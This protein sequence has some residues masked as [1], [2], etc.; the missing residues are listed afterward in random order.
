MS[1]R[2]PA[3]ANRA[4]FLSYASQDVDAARQICAALRSAGVEV[5]FDADGGLEHGDEWDAKIRRQIKECVLF[6]PL[7]SAS[8]QARLEGYFRIEWELAAER[9]MG[10]ASGVPFILPIVI[11]DTREADALV[12]DRFRK[13]Q[14][15]R[16]PA[17]AV[18]PEVQARLLKLWSHR[19]GVLSHQAAP[20][21]ASS[22]SRFSRP[23]LQLDRGLAAIVFTDVVGYSQRMQR[24][25]A[26]TMA[27]VKADFALIRE[28]CTDQGGEVLNTM[29]DGLLL[30]FP[31]AV[32]AVTCA[33]QIQSEFGARRTLLPPEQTLAHRMGVHIGDVFRQEAGGVAGDGV[34]IAARLEGKAPPGGVCISQTVYD[35]VKG[36]VPMQA[37]FVG[38]ESFKNITQPIPVWHIAAEG[39]APPSRPRLSMA[40][41][42]RRRLRPALTVGVVA[43]AVAGGWLWS[44]RAEPSAAMTAGPTAAKKSAVAPARDQSVAVL[45][46]TNL[47]EDKANEYFSDGVCEELLTVLQKIPGL[48]VVARTSAFSFKGT[49]ATAQQIGAALGAALLVDGS[50]Q[51]AGEVVRIVVHV[52]RTATGEQVWSEDYRWEKKE[53]LFTKQSEIAQTVV[54]QL[55]GQLGGAPVD[56]A[57]KAEIK[58]QVQAAEK[59]GTKN[60]EAHELFLRGRSGFSQLSET[61]AAKRLD[62]FQR[63][64]ELD[65]QFAQAWAWVARVYTL[66]G[67]WGRTVADVDENFVQARRAADRALEL[68]PDLAEGYCARMEIQC[69]YDFNWTGAKRSLQRALA[70][71]PTNADI[72][73]SGAR[74]ACVFNQL[75]QALAL[76]RQALQ[77]DPLNKELR[78]ETMVWQAEIHTQ[79]GR[80]SEAETEYQRIVELGGAGSHGDLALNQTLQRKYAEAVATASQEKTEWQ[81]LL[82]LAVAQWGQGNR[83]EAEAALQKFVADYPEMCAYQIAMAYAYR[84]EA[85]KAFAW[86][87][88]AYRQR[89]SGF[90]WFLS[91]P[92]LRN[93]HADP[94]W[95]A[96]VRKLGLAEDQLK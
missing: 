75:D 90:Q 31:S 67:Q 11:D 94:R 6:L 70:L 55:R 81:R 7:V 65:P 37:V 35:T 41:H 14:W 45:P 3:A 51:K 50:V 15:T 17:G 68:E 92:F 2:Q 73:A 74:L 57:A 40:R 9:A 19:V 1:D 26:G 30:C 8:T 78:I 56:L 82:A 61:G 69:A 53:D 13:V 64:V 20:G 4:V 22:F 58:A 76:T 86:L 87:E 12:P 91:D 48:H 89:D 18:T 32:Q 43:L 27:L 54:E 34:N 36:K 83:A 52:S 28:R 25:E 63:A 84:Q 60:P 93:L 62:Y 88:R 85:D 42:G 10:I 23:G 79:A 44:R 46:F 38:P 24:D 96:F 66:K 59:G 95:P 49:N 21:T 47:S 5:W 71:A 33:L 29:G 39:S 16:L 72:I 80:L 77:L